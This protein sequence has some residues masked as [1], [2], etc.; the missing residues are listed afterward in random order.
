M[1]TAKGLG[2]DTIN[3]RID[4]ADAA[5]V[6]DEVVDLMRKARDESS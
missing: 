2:N 1:L 3:V 4:L 6:D 5:D